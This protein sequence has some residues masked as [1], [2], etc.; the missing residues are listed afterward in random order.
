MKFFN[1]TF[2]EKNHLVLISLI[3]PFRKAKVFEF[4]FKVKF[5]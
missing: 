2:Y 5:V 4:K 1:K 3:A